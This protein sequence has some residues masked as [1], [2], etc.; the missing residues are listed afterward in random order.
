MLYTYGKNVKCIFIVGNKKHTTKRGC[1]FFMFEKI[2]NKLLN[3]KWTLYLFFDGYLIKKVKIDPNIEITKQVLLIKVHGFKT[4]FGKN[5]IALM[6][7]P[8][9][10]LKTDVD[11]RKTYWGVGFEKGVDANEW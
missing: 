1:V 5:N 10:L 3:N 4:L 6:V 9:R 8:I 7:R 11:K 2:K